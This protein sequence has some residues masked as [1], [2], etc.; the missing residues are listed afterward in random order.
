MNEINILLE[1]IKKVHRKKVD[2]LEERV[3]YFRKD[4]T[5]ESHK[6]VKNLKSTIEKEFKCLI[7]YDKYSN[8]NLPMELKCDCN[9]AYKMCSMCDLKMRNCSLGHKC[10]NCSYLNPNSVI[11][12]DVD[13]VKNRKLLI[14][15]MRSLIIDSEMGDDLFGFVNTG[16]FLPKKSTIIQ[17]LIKSNRI[18]KKKRKKKKGEKITKILKIN[19]PFSKLS[20]GYLRCKRCSYSVK[21]EKAM[22]GHYIMKHV[23]IE[24]I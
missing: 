4:L 6:K 12:M 15:E 8:S 16:A 20:N 21:T 22:M 19:K 5:K 24:I 23:T 18:T 3:A 11:C 2:K 13:F 10:P 9:P 1:N 14:G 7:C 17:P